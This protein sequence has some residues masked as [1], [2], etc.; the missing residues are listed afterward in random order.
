MEMDGEKSREERNALLFP[1]SVFC[2][3]NHMPIG[4]LA[5]SPPGKTTLRARPPASSASS[6]HLVT[7]T[8]HILPSSGYHLLR[9]LVTLLSLVI[10]ESSPW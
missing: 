1:L 7:L 9:C 6:S 5:I 3:E 8:T 2:G 4:E 10:R